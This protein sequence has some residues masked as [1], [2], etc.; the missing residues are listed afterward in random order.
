MCSNYFVVLHCSLRHETEQE[1]LSLRKWK[2]QEEEREIKR[3]Q[4]SFTGEENMLREK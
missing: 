4:R 2:Q 1:I 3:L